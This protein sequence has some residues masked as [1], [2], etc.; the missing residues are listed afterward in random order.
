[1]QL[2]EGLFCLTLTWCAGAWWISTRTTTALDKAREMQLNAIVCYLVCSASLVVWAF[3]ARRMPRWQ[4]LP[5]AV[6][7]AI[8]TPAST[9]MLHKC[10]R[11]YE[12]LFWEGPQICIELEPSAA[13]K[14][15]FMYAAAL[16]LT[17]LSALLMHQL[18]L[19]TFPRVP[20]MWWNFRHVGLVR[21]ELELPEPKVSLAH[22]RVVWSPLSRPDSLHMPRSL[23]V[24]S[25]ESRRDFP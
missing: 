13:W 5:G 4:M 6:A 3:T 18:P 14:L 11:D 16:M 7:F 2:T 23:A 24:Q 22:T 12:L 15:R 25:P 8:V 21:E 10:L 20:A 17:A 1:M 19:A 9:A